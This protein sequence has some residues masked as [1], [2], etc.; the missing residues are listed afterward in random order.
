[1]MLVRV[2]LWVA[3]L[4]CTP[5]FS[6]IHEKV[7]ICGTVKNAARQLKKSTHF[8]E[9]IGKMFDDYRVIIYEN[10]SSDPTAFLLRQWRRKNR[11][12]KL[13]SEQ[14]SKKQIS[15]IGRNWHLDNGPFRIDFI[16]H[17]RNRVLDALMCDAYK[18]FPYVIWMDMDFVLAPSY[19][20]IKEVFKSKREWDAVFAYGINS[21]GGFYDWYALRDKKYPLGPDIL[22]DYW[23]DLEKELS[24]KKSD[25]WYPVMSA[26]GGCGVYKRKSIEGCRYDGVVTPALSKMVSGI[27]KANRYKGHPLV[28]KYH[29]L[30]HGVSHLHHFDPAKR[31]VVNYTD[32]TLGFILKGDPLQIIWRM[33]FGVY[34]YPSVCEHVTFHA[35]MAQKGHGKFF[36]NPRMVF[37]YGE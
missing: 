19:D 31:E 27:V 35:A 22:G 34:R 5:I 14:L 8:V 7:V 13:I 20:G 17:A 12:V 25:D 4:A 16:T 1:M 11:R 33:N 30:N 23:W 21:E 32:E 10:N 2:F 24:F 3:C 37:R 6:K 18:D 26:F 29:E 28:K 15:R 9:Q 36:I